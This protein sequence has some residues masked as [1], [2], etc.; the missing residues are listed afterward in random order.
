M[1][2]IGAVVYRLGNEPDTLS[3]HW[4][5]STGDPNG[6]GSGVARRS[7]KGG[8]GFAGRWTVSYRRAD[9]TDGGHYELEIDQDDAVY[10]LRWLRDGVVLFEG[11]GFVADGAL[12]GGWR[13]SADR[14]DGTER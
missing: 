4:V 12:I 5:Y 7:D 14:A 3:A 13:P 6:V 1:D 2:E 11:V 9:G 8:T 10:A